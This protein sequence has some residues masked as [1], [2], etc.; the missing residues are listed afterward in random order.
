MRRVAS[1][2]SCIRPRTRNFVSSGETWNFTV[3]SERFSEAAISLLAR[4]HMTPP[5]TS[6]SRRV[7]LTERPTECPACSSFSAFSVRPFG[8]FRRGFHHHRI[9]PGRLTPS[10]HAMHYQ[11]TGR[12]LDGKL[13]VRTRLDVKRRDAR[14]LFVEK[15]CSM[16]RTLTGR[17][18]RI[19][20]LIVRLIV[21]AD[22]LD[23]RPSVARRN[24]GLETTRKVSPALRE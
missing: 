20:F 8:G 1:R 9:V 10:D 6:C 21:S 3:R 15:I 11:Q 22:Y 7:N 2:T 5:N 18:Q 12:F 16:G 24:F 13:A 19:S 4:L 14:A 23:V 17:S